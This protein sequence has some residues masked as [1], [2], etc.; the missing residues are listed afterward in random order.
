MSTEN[1]VND[2]YM[3]RAYNLQILERCDIFLFVEHKQC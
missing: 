2:L 1:K 3:Y